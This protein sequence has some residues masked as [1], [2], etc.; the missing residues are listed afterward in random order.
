MDATLFQN[1]ANRPEVQQSSKSS[2]QY[3]SAIKYL[4]QETRI[5]LYLVSRNRLQN[6]LEVKSLKIPT[7]TKSAVHM[8]VIQLNAYDREEFSTQ[9]VY[10]SCPCEQFIP[11]IPCILRDR[12]AVGNDC[13]N[14]LQRYDLLRMP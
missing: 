10:I 14:A 11:Y 3:W 13:S 7:T 1:T 4:L 9:R 5:G 2:A 8:H 12:G 6:K